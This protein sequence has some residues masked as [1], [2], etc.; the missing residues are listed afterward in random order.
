MIAWATIE[1]ALVAWLGA[2]TG[3]PVIVANQ[4]GPQPE[5]PYVTIQMMSVPTRSDELRMHPA[6]EGE[7][8]RDVQLEARGERQ[9]TLA[10]NVYGPQGE[11]TAL[12]LAEKIRGSL[13]LPSVLASLREVGLS[14]IDATP[15]QDLTWLQDTEYVE[16]RQM[17]V[18]FALASSVSEVVEGIATVEVE[19]EGGA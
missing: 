3:R 1:A 15:I 10:I 12:E 16:R 6:P 14:F 8:P 2:Q 4:T 17:D 5:K 19:Q 9:M 13:G 7:D 11:T 18:R